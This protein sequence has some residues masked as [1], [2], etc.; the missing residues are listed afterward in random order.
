[1]L[2][3]IFPVLVTATVVGVVLPAFSQVD[4]SPSPI[5]VAQSRR[6][7]EIY[8]DAFLSYNNRDYQQA[9]A[10]VNQVIIEDDRFGPAYY[11]RGLLRNRDGRQEAAIEDFTNAIALIPDNANQARQAYPS[12]TYDV[13]KQ[14]RDESYYNRGLAYYE[15]GNVQ[16]AIN[17]LVQYTRRLPD[18]S[19]GFYRLGFFQVQHNQSTAGLENLRRAT[20]LNPNHFSAVAQYGISRSVL[21]GDY[22]AGI[23]TAAKVLTL[24][25]PD[26]AEDYW[27]LGQAYQTL[28]NLR[29]AEQAYTQAINLAEASGNFNYVRP[30]IGRA[31]VRYLLQDISGSAVDIDAIGERNRL[32]DLWPVVAFS[33][34]AYD[35]GNVPYARDLFANGFSQFP[36]NAI[37]HLSRGILNLQ[38]EAI[39]A[40]KADFDRAISL[41]QGFVSAYYWRSFVQPDPQSA[42]SDLNRAL[43][44]NPNYVDALVQRAGWLSELGDNERSRADY[45]RAGRLLDAASANEGAAAIV[46][47]YREEVLGYLWRNEGN[48]ENAKTNFNSARQRYTQMGNQV[49]VKRM[50]LASLETELLYEAGF[51]SFPQ[52]GVLR[53][54]GGRA[55]AEANGTLVCQNYATSGQQPNNRLCEAR[56]YTGRRNETVTFRVISNDFDTYLYVLAPDGRVLEE[57]DDIDL[58]QNNLNSE[59][60]IRLP[61]DGQYTL[62]IST[63]DATGEGRFS[64]GTRQE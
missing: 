55:L 9:N 29:Q 28:G 40:A 10:L 23:E 11:L 45:E 58:S 30:Y 63:Y 56:T 38:L 14:V 25:E 33:D 52:Q 34:I 48:Y 32:N 20:E 7:L 64:L 37:L 42:I 15:L 62:I 35:F 50:T 49:A 3:K 46:E 31:V 26:N 44:I 22:A 59:V 18:S 21:L 51:T 43:T 27:N 60:T 4:A 54:P 47:A 19:E 1:M 17:D 16:Q 57:N 2:H 39:D 36:N 6:T 13:L 12:A 5:I 24:E 53:R 41:D 61:Q 8:R